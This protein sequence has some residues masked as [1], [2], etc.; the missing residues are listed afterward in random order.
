[1]LKKHQK[2]LFK[3]KKAKFPKVAKTLETFYFMLYY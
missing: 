3:P 1:M 2:P